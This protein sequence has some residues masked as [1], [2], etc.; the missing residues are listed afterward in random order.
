MRYGKRF[1]DEDEA[2]TLSTAP[3]TQRVNRF[4]RRRFA[5]K[6]IMRA[7]DRS[8]EE[9]EPRA[10]RSALAECNDAFREELDREQRALT[11]TIWALVAHW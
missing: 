8:L 3:S 9:M 4:W 2:D 10:L 1:A 11:P 7:T 5:S 6:D